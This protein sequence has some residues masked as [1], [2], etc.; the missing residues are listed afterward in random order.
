MDNVEHIKQLAVAT[1][2]NL[3]KKL[4]IDPPITRQENSVIGLINFCDKTLFLCNRIDELEGQLKEVK[5]MLKEA[6]K[7]ELRR[8]GN[9]GSNPAAPVV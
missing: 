1:R 6:Q 2:K 4:K 9:A 7:L 5:E 3:Y 8:V